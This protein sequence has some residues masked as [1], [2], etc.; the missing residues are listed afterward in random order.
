M[1]DVEN[2]LSISSWYRDVGRKGLSLENIPEDERTPEMCFV[3]VR[4]WGAALEHVPNKYKTYELCLDAV[5][6]NIP[7][8]E[9]CSALAFVPEKHKTY[10]L[11]LEAVKHDY[12][13]SMFWDADHTVAFD[14]RAA[15]DFVPEKLKTPELCFEVL[16]HHPT[17]MPGYFHFVDIQFDSLNFSAAKV[18]PKSISDILSSSELLLHS[19]KQIGM[20]NEYIEDALDYFKKDNIKKSFL[21]NQL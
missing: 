18:L 9:G 16:M 21:R 1:E 7:V 4:Y 17:S 2:Q 5:R 6:H 12:M 8:D 3:A 20:P 13:N 11:C 19:L 15:I 10:E 14:Y